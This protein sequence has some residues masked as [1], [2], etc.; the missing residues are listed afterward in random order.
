MALSR[1]LR[2]L[3]LQ[4]L[5]T[6]A[7]LIW[8]CACFAGDIL[9]PNE[10][11]W[12]SAHPQI[13][14][15]V[16]PDYPPISFLNARG[17]PTG[18]ENDY[19]TLLEARLG[20][21][22]KRVIPTLAQR[23]ADNPEDKQ[24][25]MVPT[26]ASTTN[27]LKN[28]HFTKPYL[29]FPVYLIT[30]ENAPIKFSL[31]NSQQ[32]Q[33]SVVGHY[34]VYDF[35]K[36]KYPSVKI[37]KVDDTCIGL[38]RVAIG[39]S[40]GLLAD[41][42]VANWCTKQYNLKNLKIAQALGFHYE[43]SI[44]GR[45]DW[46][47]LSSILEKGLASISQQ[48]RDEIYLRWNKNSLEKNFFAAYANWIICSFLMLSGLLLFRLFQWDNKLK[49]SLEKRFS[50]DGFLELQQN[51]H[52]SASK[53]I[54][55]TNLI[56]FMV[57]LMIVIA[58]LVYSYIY[59]NKGEDSFLGIIE[60]VVVLIGLLGGFIL[61][62]IWRR[63]QADISFFQLQ[64]QTKQRVAAEQQLSGINQRQVKQQQALV[65]LTRRQ[66]QPWQNA[67]DIYREIAQAAAKTLKAD[68]A[69]V[70]LFDESNQQLNCM[71]LYSASKKLHTV[72][73]PLQAKLLPQYFK[74][75]LGQRFI[76]VNDAYS[77]PA[78]S[79]LIS[80]YLPDNNI[81]AML[82]GTIWLNDKVVGVVCIEHIGGKRDWTLDEQNFVGSLTDYCRVII[83]TCKRRSAEQSL[84]QLSAR[85]EAIIAQRTQ[86]LR[87]SESRYSYVI[88]HAPIPI[89]VIANDGN[90]VDVN[91]E[92]LLA[93]KYKREDLIG[94]NFIQT[95]VA[96][97]SRRKAL[98]TAAQ[99]LKGK[100]F[101]DV[102]LILQSTDGNKVEFLCSIGL[103]HRSE[104]DGT[105]KMVAIAQNI[106]QQK[107]LQ[108]NLIVAREAAESADRIKSM[109]VA[110]MS[111]ELRTPLNS[112]IGFLG[113]VLQGMSGELN[114]K[115]KDQLSRAYHS[116][117][118]LLSL[119]SDVI[120]ISK[121]EAGFLQTHIE[122]VYLKQLFSEVEHAVMHLAEAKHLALDVDCDDDLQLQTDR[123]RLYQVVLNVVS[124][125]LKYTEQGAVKVT[126]AIKNEMLIIAVEDTGIGIA[127]SDMD[128]L[129][130][131]FE[132]IESR[133]KVKTLGTGLGLYLTRKILAQLLGGTIE[134]KSVLGV[135]STFSI[136]VPL[137]APAIL[138]NGASIL[139]EPHLQSPNKKLHTMKPQKVSLL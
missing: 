15:A 39:Q 32:Q 4:L 44:A 57:L 71:S 107:A 103:I 51:Q 131:P 84:M 123:K 35:F 77:N 124:N 105:E 40:A 43:L 60:I 87:E 89:V 49:Q 42:P 91:P 64:T 110:S 17:Q 56:A 31:E 20:Y 79:E 8:Q 90:I 50:N 92:A 93:G 115:Q 65:G 72:A 23:A 53:K 6:A 2:V 133:L 58:T 100:K 34:A 70:W 125:A 126:A 21:Q 80:S 61:G 67:E 129:F 9:S 95:V 111:H 47:Q 25:D 112:I 119:I 7:L 24:V 46:P 36:Q 117:K 134:V 122:K 96:K 81:G 85:Q 102:E 11:A 30:Q 62:S 55:Q 118:H 26:F 37:D 69:S 98:F 54:M 139:E 113:V 45:K 130:K 1:F 88:E 121:I 12:L 138:Q 19:L 68:R 106:S 109:F 128:D 97:E 82:D 52:L 38:Q 14:V 101:R 83:E 63:Y 127:E 48:E 108:S 22:F 99:T 135:G 76:A 27:R 116:A 136:K 66:L 94:K 73:K 114:V 33:V 120:D 75:L 86:L 16:S 18:L 132:R 5:L 28:W 104:E 3:N 10:R 78:T 137:L 13:R 41:L 74:H 29:D 59:Y